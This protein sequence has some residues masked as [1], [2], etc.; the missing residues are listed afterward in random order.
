M[1]II[2][3]KTKNTSSII[4]TSFQYFAEWKKEQGICSILGQIFLGNADEAEAE[5]LK[6]KSWWCDGDDFRTRMNIRIM[7]LSCVLLSFLKMFRKKRKMH[8]E[9][10]V[11]RKEGSFEEKKIEKGRKKKDK[12]KVSFCF[13]ARH[14]TWHDMTWHMARA[15][16]YIL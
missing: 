16:L 14:V 6:A 2:S 7:I 10:K 1:M 15:T 12:E 9:K 3:K 13:E 4:I 11:V 5:W 8:S